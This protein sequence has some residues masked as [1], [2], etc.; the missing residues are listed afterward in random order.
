MI[1]TKRA[2]SKF[3]ARI[4]SVLH[5][6]VNNYKKKFKSFCII[7]NLNAANKREGKEKCKL[8]FKYQRTH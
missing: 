5:L 7:E 3:I 1:I 2:L 4:L 6:F 8:D